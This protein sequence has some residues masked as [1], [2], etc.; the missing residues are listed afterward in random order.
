M[1]HHR[2]ARVY[3]MRGFLRGAVNAQT[4]G[5]PRRAHMLASHARRGHCHTGNGRG[6]SSH[7]RTPTPRTR[8]GQPGWGNPRSACSTCAARN[9]ASAHHALRT[10]RKMVQSRGWARTSSPTRAT[11][12]RGISSTKAAPSTTTGVQQHFL[13]IAA[14]ARGGAMTVTGAATAGSASTQVCPQTQHLGRATSGAHVCRRRPRTTDSRTVRPRAVR[15]GR[16]LGPV[17][18]R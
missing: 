7:P 2:G 5:P 9:G 10:H 11:G 17:T 8:S 12:L 14:R 15:G 18:A 13:R 16:P 1:N 6:R 3:I 4:G